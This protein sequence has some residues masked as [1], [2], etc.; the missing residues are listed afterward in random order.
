MGSSD[1]RIIPHEVAEA[2]NPAQPDLFRYV[3]TYATTNQPQFVALDNDGRLILVDDQ[4]EA[5]R[6]GSIAGAQKRLKL[7]IEAGELQL[8]T[9]LPLDL[10]SIR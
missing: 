4:K 1:F 5:V 6:F 2:V 10:E 7:A 3:I 9:G 8:G